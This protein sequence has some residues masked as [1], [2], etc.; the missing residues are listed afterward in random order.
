VE[1]ESAVRDPPF[2]PVIFYEV[3]NGTPTKL[4]AIRGTEIHPDYLISPASKIEGVSTVSAAKV[5]YPPI[6]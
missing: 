3:V 6:P 5:H 1:Q 4:F 2:F